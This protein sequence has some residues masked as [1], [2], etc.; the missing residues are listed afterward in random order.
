M[1]YAAEHHRHQPHAAGASLPMQPELA[2]NWQ[3]YKALLQEFIQQLASYIT[4]HAAYTAA[5][6]HALAT[7]A[8][9]VQRAAVEAPC[10]APGNLT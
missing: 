7:L 10:Q 6:G 9:P 5:D 8:L 4:Q 2:A 3:D 1:S